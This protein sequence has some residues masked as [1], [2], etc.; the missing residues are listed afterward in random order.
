MNRYRLIF[1]ALSLLTL[2]IVGYTVTGSLDFFLADFW[3]ASGLLLLIL[4]SLVDQPHF[5]RDAHVF[6]NAVTGLTALL[7]VSPPGRDSVWFTFFGW[8]MYLVTSSYA[9]MMIRSRVLAREGRLTRLITRLNRAIGRPEAIF[10][11][12]FI[13]GL[14]KQFGPTADAYRT[15]LWFW[16]AFIVLNIPAVSSALADFF[17]RVSSVQP[18]IVGVVQTVVS[19]KVIE[20]RIR[21]DAPQD[22]VGARFRIVT[23]DDRECAHGVVLDD[24]IMAKCRIAKLAIVQQS[25]AWHMLSADEEGNGQTSLLLAP[26]QDGAPAVHPI[27]VVDRG[28]DI[29]NLRFYVNPQVNLQEGEVLWVELPSSVRAY[30]QIVAAQITEEAAESENAVQ[31]VCVSAGQLGIWNSQRSRFEPIQWVAP[32]GELIYKVTATSTVETVIPEEHASVGTVPNSEFP[33][34][35][36]LQDVVTHNT[37][38]IG[39]TGSGKSYLSFLLIEALTT[40]NI[41][42]L[43]LDLTRQHWVYLEPSRPQ[44]LRTINELRDWLATDHRIGIYQFA[45]ATSYPAATANFVE[46]VFTHF[47][48]TVRMQPGTNEPARLCVVLEEA[49]S[50]IPEWNQVAVEDDKRQ[51]NRTARYILQGRKYGLGCILI[52]QRTA[53]VTKTILNQCNTIFAMQSFDQTGLDF[54]RNYMGE[55]YAHAISTLATR[56]AV[57]VGKASS[58]A[59]PILFRVNDLTTHWHTGEMAIA[60]RGVEAPATNPG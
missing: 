30:Y 44:A 45:D 48:S 4:L 24:R 51:V 52:T 26:S 56:H 50:L 31:E 25:S 8:S 58:S 42:V 7:T 19:P 29:T 3:F 18:G 12:F 47:E 11:A 1:L 20:A 37:A 14:L 60:E 2:S 28:S 41:R 15:L 27:S 23:R 36:D 21:F 57:L 38:I 39:V 13:W 17:A 43:I 22:I 6:L 33:V 16:G 46:T 34:H 53:N 5:S 54:L 55:S 9:L 35:V 32:A 40:A 49:H 10:S 59:R